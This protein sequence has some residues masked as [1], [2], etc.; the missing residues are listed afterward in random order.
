[1]KWMRSLQ[2]HS[3]PSQPFFNAPAMALV[4]PVLVLLTHGIFQVLPEIRQQLVL[5]GTVLSPER[6]FSA[7]D[8][9]Y[10]YGGL[11]ERIWPMFGSALLHLDWTH[12]IV[13]AAMILAA[14]AA[15]PRWTGVGARGVLVYWAVVFFSQL[16]AAL[17]HLFSYYPDGA[18]AVGAS[19]I[20]SGLVGAALLILLSARNRRSRLKL[21]TTQNGMILIGFAIFNVI[22]AGGFEATSGIR[23]AW[24]AHVGGFIAGA[25]SIWWLSPRPLASRG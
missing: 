19:G 15:L 16:G 8:A 24:Q 11:I 9:R 10:A 21:L 1:M 17:A 4:L 3:E 25:L 14:G 2:K 12:A 5:Y 22:F 6:F 13:N 18:G 23:I 20:A 7:P